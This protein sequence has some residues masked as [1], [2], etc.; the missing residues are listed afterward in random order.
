MIPMPA[1]LRQR[2][3]H[4]GFRDRVH[5]GADDG[6]I[7]AD[8]ARELCLCVGLRRN[9]VGTRRQQQHVVE[10]E[11][12]RNRKMN[13]KLSRREY[14]L[15]SRRSGRLAGKGSGQMNFQNLSF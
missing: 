12:F 1:L 14:L 2:N 9:N 6:N 4:V 3:R 10:G 5:G 13:H 8:V 7:Q 15:F 11:S